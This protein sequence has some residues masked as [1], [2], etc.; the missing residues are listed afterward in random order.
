M[1]N[2]GQTLVLFV[3]LIPLIFV[4]LG[5]VI[6]IGLLTNEKNKVDNAVKD[7][8][9]NSLTTE[10]SNNQTMEEKV[11]YLINSNVENIIINKIEYKDS[12]LYLNVSKEYKTIFARILNQK[13]YIIDMK[14]K[15]YI[16]NNKVIIKKE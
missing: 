7:S 14:Y 8:I 10:L 9:K 13:K 15:A 2:K 11:V 12:I 1:D 6:D 16:E 5:L 4:L 3:I